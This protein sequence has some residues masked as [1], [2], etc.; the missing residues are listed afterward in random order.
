MHVEFRMRGTG[1]RFLRRFAVG[2]VI[3]VCLGLGWSLSVGVIVLLAVVFGLAI[4]VHVWL[5]APVDARLV[6]SPASVLRNDRVAAVSFSLSLTAS[7]G[8]F[9]GLAF[10][11]TREVR[12]IGVLDDRFDLALVLAGGVAAALLGYFLMRKVGSAA[13]GFA[14]AVVGGLV[15]PRAT[16]PATAFAV[17][18]VFGLAVGLTMCLARAWGASVLTRLWLASRGSTPLRLM[19]FL[20]DAHRRGVLRQVGAVY[21]FRHVRLEER[22]AARVSQAPKRSVSA[23]AAGREGARSKVP[24]AGRVL[25]VSAPEQ[26][27]NMPVTRRS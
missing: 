14:G 6:S 16:D 26:R 2:V 3:A 22:L 20:D 8:L 12:F 27:G 19:R 24:A 5:G 7:L 11:F 9:Y 23:R 4:G 21:Q 1:A 15:F 13:F 18:L 17:G 10:A 25:E